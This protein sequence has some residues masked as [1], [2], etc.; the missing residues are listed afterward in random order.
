MIYNNADDKTTKITLYQK[1]NLVFNDAV[2]RVASVIKSKRLKENLNTFIITGCAPKVGSTTVAINLA[3]A[4]AKSGMKVVLI[5]SD[6]RKRKK[7]LNEK[8]KCGLSNYLSHTASIEQILYQTDHANLNYIASGITSMDSANLIHSNSLNELLKQV[9]ANH[10]IILF[11]SPSLSAAADAEILSAK[12][13]AVILVAE[14]D[15]TSTDQV[16]SVKRELDKSG[17]NIIGVILNKV[18]KKEYKK[19]LNDYDYINKYYK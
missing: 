3:I 10:D 17:V 6:M 1:E 5:D 15:S 12:I 18:T 11:D 13:S 4:L 2:N 8:T 19:H 9:S 14:F 7:H 16:K